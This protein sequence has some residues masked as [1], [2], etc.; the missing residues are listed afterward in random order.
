[1]K[2]VLSRRPAGASTI[3]ITIVQ[4]DGPSFPTGSLVVAPLT[5]PA[6]LPA[7]LGVTGIGTST[8]TFLNPQA[9][10]RDGGSAAFD[11]AFHGGTGVS[12][13]GA[14]TEWSMTVS[15]TAGDGTCNQGRPGAWTG[16]NT[17]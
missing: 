12:R 6:G 14:A 4:T 7:P 13:V 10:L 2:D 17:L 1:M 3:T 16:P 9:L 15:S 11:I 8:V 5:A